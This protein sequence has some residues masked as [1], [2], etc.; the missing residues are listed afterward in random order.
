[1][2]NKKTPDIGGVSSVHP[3]YQERE[4]D[5]QLVEDSF[6]GERIV[7]ESRSEYLPI[8]SGLLEENGTLTDPI[9]IKAYDAYIIRAEYP[10]HFSD[11]IDSN[12]G[13]MHN[14]PT[15]IILPKKMKA[16]LDEATPDGKTMLGLIREIHFELLTKGRV[17]LFVDVKENVQGRALPH[18]LLYTTENI[19][20]WGTS[21]MIG[22]DKLSFVVLDESKLIRHEFTWEHEEIYRVIEEIDGKVTVT[23][24]RRLKGKDNSFS[25][26]VNLPTILSKVVPSFPMVIIGTST[27]SP[28]PQKP[29]FLSLAD[30][31]MGIY[32][33]SA[34]YN[35]TLYMQ[36]QDTLVTKGLEDDDNKTLAVG[37][38]ARINVS[39]GGDVKFVGVESKGLSEQRL[40]IENATK[41]AVRQSTTLVDSAKGHV[42]RQSGSAL[43]TRLE[44]ETSTL[45]TI[46]IVAA[47]GLERSLKTIAKWMGLDDKGVSVTPHI[48]FSN[49][50]ITPQDMVAL[51]TAKNAGYPVS[52]KSMHDLIVKNGLTL[53]SFEEET[54]LL[55]KEFE[56]LLDQ[57][58]TLKPEGLLGDPP[59]KEMKN[60]PN[61]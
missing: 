44:S 10:S 50:D 53:L 49:D 9:K 23:E 54:K 18:I 41:L 2:A 60:G 61:S 48:E 5:W 3:L 45:N 17:G 59:A 55:E 19:R 36:G 7:K 33:K 58:G 40:A 39:T 13:L 27:I 51:T 46:A 35:M 32:R 1:M 25:I 34:D 11:A 57:G 12:I 14:E 6:Q 26:T 52:S 24:H 21:N 43:A 42:S 56:E 29:P 4:C 15:N 16:L 8:P 47:E 37:A 28:D 31:C 22:D 20:N 38:N 30:K